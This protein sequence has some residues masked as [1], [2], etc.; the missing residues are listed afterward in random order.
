MRTNKIQK[1]KFHLLI[2]FIKGFQIR[3]NHLC[4]IG[5]KSDFITIKLINIYIKH[6]SNIF[7]KLSMLV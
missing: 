7:T 2:Y 6:F 4:Y 3:E 1:L 5:N